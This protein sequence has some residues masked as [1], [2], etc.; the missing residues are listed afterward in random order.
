MAGS[1]SAAVGGCCTFRRASRQ[2]PET[3]SSSK[4]GATAPSVVMSATKLAMFLASRREASTGIVD[5]ASFMPDDRDRAAVDLH[6][7]VLAG[8][9]ALDVAAGLRREVDDD[10][11]RRACPASIALVMS[12]GAG[13]PGIAAVVM[14]MS[15][16]A[17]CGASS[18][19]W[20]FARS[21]ASSLA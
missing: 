1:T 14:M 7:H 2:A 6:L 18:S 13:R 4:S 19:C 21:A 5:A 12:F 20:R 15:A 9:A 11:T 3:T 16:S 8:H 10:R 17:T